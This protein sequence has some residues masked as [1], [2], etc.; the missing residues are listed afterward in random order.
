MSDLLVSKIDD[1][2]PGFL[3][4]SDYGDKGKED[5]AVVFLHAYGGCKEEL[6]GLAM[7]TADSVND[8]YVYDL[9]GHGESRSVFISENINIFIKGI[10]EQLSGYKSIYF[11]GHSIGA[12]IALSVG[13]EKVVAI[14]PPG[15]TI[16]EGRQTEL[17]QTL[18]VR[19]VKEEAP[20]E[21]LKTVLSA[22]SDI[23]IN[24]ESCLV[25]Y[26]KNDIR[27]SRNMA[28]SLGDRDGFSAKQITASN[29]LDIITSRDTIEEVRKFIWM[30]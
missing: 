21:G 18:R 12:R 10:R 23:N 4:K 22:F 24:I 5:K 9:P 3:I 14:S 13:G 8:C 7:N 1:I 2:S 25:L 30:C 26:A 16:F 15:E 29:H 17:L 28:V 27:S 20:Y 6:V 19:R 11:L